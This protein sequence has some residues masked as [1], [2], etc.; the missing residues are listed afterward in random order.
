MPYNMPINEVFTKS[1][2]NQIYLRCEILKKGLSI[3][4]KRKNIV[5]E[6]KKS[7][8]FQGFK[9]DFEELLGYLYKKNIVKKSGREKFSP[10]GQKLTTEK[11]YLIKDNV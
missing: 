6:I 9:I 8:E 4:N 1:I 11:V 5:E 3:Y 7:E 10:C 2:E